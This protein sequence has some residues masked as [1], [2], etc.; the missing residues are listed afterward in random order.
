MTDRIERIETPAAMAARA[1]AFARDGARVGFVPTMGALHDGHLE[2]VRTARRENDVAVVS[3]F[4]NPLQFG[5]NED[6]NRYPR[7][8]AGDVAK[9]APAGCD[10]VFATNADAMYPPG[11]A[12]YVVN[13][14][15]T[16]RFEG[17]IRPGHFRGV[18]TVVAKLFHLV[19][20]TIA[21][22][23]QKDAQQAL[24]IRRMVTDLDFPLKVSVQPTVR[25]PDGL[26]RSS[27]NAFL[28]SAGRTRGL[29]LSRGLRAA[30]ACFAAGERRGAEL[31]GAARR[32]LEATPEVSIDYVALVDADTLD[33]VVS[34]N[35]RALML[36]AARVDGV[37]LLDNALLAAPTGAAW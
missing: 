10:V 23:G 22:F 5:P 13:D 1:A 29:A 20:P 36:V 6:F 4:V 18:L 34:A 27:R 8:L 9:L 17:A 11:F 19:R 15:L 35:E 12:T 26:A 25:E 24:L 31:I 14:A 7:D 33:D 16:D 2:L 28:S 30:A 32:E 3:I 21:Y 37:R